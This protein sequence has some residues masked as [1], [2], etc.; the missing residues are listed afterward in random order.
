VTPTI[1]G[2]DDLRGR[3]ARDGL[4]GELRPQ[5]QGQ[6][7]EEGNQ[8]PQQVSSLPL[9]FVA[10]IP[11]GISQLP[12]LV[13]CSLLA[14]TRLRTEWESQGVEEESQTPQQV[15]LL[16]FLF[17]AYEPRSCSSSLLL[18]SLEL[19]DTQVYEP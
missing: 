17:A 13:S 16:T 8:A 10:S 1:G 4:S 19:S 6:D 11:S 12:T 15:V 2:R 3:D 5:R 9:S 14:R 18:S 7:P